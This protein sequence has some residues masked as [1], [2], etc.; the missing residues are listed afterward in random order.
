M[1]LLISPAAFTF[2]ACC[3]AIV[4]DRDFIESNLSVA[5]KRARMCR[6]TIT[7]C[8]ILEHIQSQ[9]LQGVLWISFMIA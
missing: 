7:S 8:N 6:L 1:R 2:V 9:Q 4:T 3:S 5:L